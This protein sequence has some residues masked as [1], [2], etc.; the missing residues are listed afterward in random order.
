[1]T[2]EIPRT[3]CHYMHFQPKLCSGTHMA[4][5]GEQVGCQ[6]SAA[7]AAYRPW[8]PSNLQVVCTLHALSA[9]AVFLS[10]DR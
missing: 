3:V 1:M 7:A 2:V 9:K 10:G 5:G 4:S 6:W 8:L